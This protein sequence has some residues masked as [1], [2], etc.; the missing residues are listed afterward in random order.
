MAFVLYGLLGE[1]APDVSI[2][3]LATDLRT[4][5]SQTQG[6]GLE[7]EADPFDPLRRNLVLSWGAWWVRVFYETGPEVLADSITIE[8]MA[9]EESPKRRIAQI[10]RRIRVLFADD[11]GREHTNQ[12]VFVMDFLSAIPGITVFDPQRHEFVA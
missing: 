5:F 4:F 11:E 10:G 12:I 7:F 6:F 3:S 9:G 2:D 1:E 8:A